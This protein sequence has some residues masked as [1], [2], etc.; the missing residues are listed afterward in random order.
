MIIYKKIIDKPVKNYILII[1]MLS[2][3]HCKNKLE[4]LIN[5]ENYDDR[6]LLLQACLDHIQTPGA[7]NKT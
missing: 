4:S 3:L 2:N 1:E 6:V 7:Q 5:T